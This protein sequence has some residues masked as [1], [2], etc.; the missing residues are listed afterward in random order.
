MKPAAALR[1]ARAVSA[2][3]VAMTWV[4]CGPEPVAMPDAVDSGSPASPSSAARPSDIDAPDRPAPTA[5]ADSG[6]TQPQ[7]DAGVFWG[8]E[9]DAGVPG[10]GI[11]QPSRLLRFMAVGNTSSA[12]SNKTASY[13]YW[14]QKKF[15]AVPVA[16]DFVGSQNKTTSDGI[17]GEYKY[18]DFD[19]DHESYASLRVISDNQSRDTRKQMKGWVERSKPDVVLMI[20]A[21]GDIM[22]VD[23]PDYQAIAGGYVEIIKQARA[24]NKNIAIFMSSPH[25]IEAKSRPN[26]MKNLQAL[27]PYQKEVVKMMNTGDSPII[28]V[29]IWTGYDPDADNLGTTWHPSESGEKIIA[30]RFFEAFLKLRTEHPFF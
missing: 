21:M 13:R 23:K 6:V 15:D 20:L 27:I 26:S 7:A 19:P 28:F 3:L 2:A 8:D 4:S 17:A 14:L 24:A 25:P 29:D 1:A 18:K 22:Y 30:D 10:V 11:P 5:A 9:E 12:G 16:Y